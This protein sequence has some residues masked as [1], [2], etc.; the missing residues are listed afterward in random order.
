MN[1]DGRHGTGAAGGANVLGR[2]AYAAGA[3]AGWSNAPTTGSPPASGSSLS[4]TS[5]VP[6]N[7]SSGFFAIS[8]S[9]TATS[10]SGASGTSSFSG[11][12]ALNWWAIIFS[13]ALPSGKGYRPVRQ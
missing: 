5:S 1:D 3:G 11:V 12:A 6:P 7:R 2:G 8:R 13:T 4:A 10:A 9:T